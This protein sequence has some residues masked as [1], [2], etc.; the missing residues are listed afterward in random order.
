MT[1][2]LEQQYD[3]EVVYDSH[4]DTLEVNRYSTLEHIITLAN[5]KALGCPVDDEE[6]NTDEI[7]AWLVDGVEDP[8][9]VTAEDLEKRTSN[10]L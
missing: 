1:Q 4:D 10:I 2:S 6:D 5:A 9:S 8:T 7:I 3:L